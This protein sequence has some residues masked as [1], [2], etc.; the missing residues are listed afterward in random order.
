MSFRD[1]ESGGAFLKTRFFPLF[2]TLG[3]ST[4]ETSL[5]LKTP[6]VDFL[7]P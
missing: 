1:D 7:P 6:P 4:R 2:A 5:G 3:N